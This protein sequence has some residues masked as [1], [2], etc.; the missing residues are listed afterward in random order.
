[1]CVLNQGYDFIEKVSDSTVSA[2]DQEI[3]I[4]EELHVKKSDENDSVQNPFEDNR[5]I[6]HVNDHFMN[7]AAANYF[8][9]QNEHFAD[10]E[11]ELPNKIDFAEK[12]NYSEY[13]C[14]GVLDIFFVK[15]SKH[16]D[17]QSS[18]LE[19]RYFVAHVQKRILVRNDTRKNYIR[20][21]RSILLQMS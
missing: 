5:F 4:S 13:F 9:Q 18:S 21:E 15:Y 20:I 11:P 14:Y 3:D 7:S 19:S 10:D 8:E 16:L 1:M 17:S 2:K 6:D 12:E